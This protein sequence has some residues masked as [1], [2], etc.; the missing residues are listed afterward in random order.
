[1]KSRYTFL[2]LFLSLMNSADVLVAGNVAR[3]RIFTI[4]YDGDHGINHYNK[5]IT[6]AQ[7]QN[8]IEDV[9]I[10]Q[11]ALYFDAITDFGQTFLVDTLSFPVS[12][13]DT[14]HTV[15]H[16]QANIKKLQ[17]P[18]VQEELR[19]LL[20][21]VKE[22]Q[23]AVM[24]LMINRDKVVESLKIPEDAWEISKP[25]YTLLKYVEQNPWVNLSRQVGAATGAAHFAGLT[26]IQLNNVYN[27][28]DKFSE[29]IKTQHGLLKTGENLIGLGA[30][31]YYSYRASQFLYDDYQ[32]GLKN[33][34]LIH[35]LHIIVVA[36]ERVETLCKK[37]GL[38]TQFNLSAIK[39]PQGLAMIQE[40]K[41]SL[42]HEKESSMI[43]S[44]WVN[45]FVTKIYEQDIYLAPYFALIAEIDA[46]HAIATKMTATKDLQTQFC[47]AQPINQSQPKFD[48]QNFWN[49]VVPHP[50]ANSLS[51]ARSIIL[52]GPNAGG[53]STAIRSIL[54]N[55]ILAQTFGVA[56]GKHFIFTPFDVI[57][58]YLK[59]SDDITQG[60]S[61]YASELKRAS[62]TVVRAKELRHDEKLFFVLDELFTGTGGK[63]GE[64]CAYEFVNDDLAPFMHQIQF[65]FATHFDKLKEIEKNNPTRFA[66]YKIDAPTVDAQNKLHYPFTLSKGA[67]NIN[68]AMLM[69]KQ[70]G[71]LG[72]SKS[73]VG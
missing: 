60:L 48:A 17:D 71:L 66:N 38:K 4:M 62:D 26:G 72:S 61:R 16:R 9:A 43:W 53:K 57:H 33:R 30:T 54:Q 46:Y 18:A 32:K 41:H 34:N 50:I 69:K 27:N 11:V 65:I 15:H 28:Y 10:P 58:S 56:T 36:A 5:N 55:I 21:Q 29:D 24:E 2:L 6:Y 42:Y 52:T 40:L 3:D 39:D 14:N 47:F 73:Y 68:I 22:A 13:K 49:V 64:I 8:L 31:A 1:M 23:T 37:H 59:V 25:W 12:P 20:L 67:N 63:D 51:E 44:A 70:A 45:T 7:T 19:A 35:A